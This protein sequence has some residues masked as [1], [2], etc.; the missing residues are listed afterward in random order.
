MAEVNI[1]DLHLGKLAWH[2][3]T[4]ENYD[5]KI[6]RDIFYRIIAE[7]IEKL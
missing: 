7:I 2:G 4:P 5:Y 3:D 6:A 1:A